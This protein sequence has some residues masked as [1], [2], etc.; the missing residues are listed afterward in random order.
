MHDDLDLV[1]CHPEQPFRLDHLEALIHHRSGIDRDLGTHRPVR[2]LQRLRFRHMRQLLERLA[3]ERTTRG[4][5]QYLLDRVI[6][7]AS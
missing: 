3:P 1:R 6:A 7:R 5:E 4:G 2:M